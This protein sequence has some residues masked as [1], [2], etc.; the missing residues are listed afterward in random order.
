MTCE[1]PKNDYVSALARE[2]SKSLIVMGNGFASINVF[3]KRIL[4]GH[5]DVLLLEKNVQNPFMIHVHCIGELLQIARYECMCV[6]D[7]FEKRFP[8][9]QAAIQAST[10]APG[11]QARD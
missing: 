1:P 3:I 2:C 11:T 9:I 5:N 7:I 8:L 6:A 4:D 10:L